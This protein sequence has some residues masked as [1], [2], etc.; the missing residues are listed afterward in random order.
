MD[1][2]KAVVLGT[3]DS[4]SDLRQTEK[5]QV[6]TINLVTDDKGF[7]TYFKCALWGKKVDAIDALGITKGSRILVEGPLKK[8]LYTKKDG[9][10]SE[11][12]VINANEVVFL[13]DG[14]AP[15]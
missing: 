13:S 8:E 5:S 11:S 3:V 7:K 6:R 14:E 10:K 15:F 2:Q 9:S 1:Y 12:I 4:V